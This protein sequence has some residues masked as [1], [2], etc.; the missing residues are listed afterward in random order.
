[1]NNE[2]YEQLKKIG[3]YPNRKVST[4][5]P[6]CLKC[7]VNFIEEYG[8]LRYSNN[9]TS[10]HYQFIK[11]FNILYLNEIELVPIGFVTN[12]IFGTLG[13][14]INKYE[15]IYV[16]DYKKYHKKIA[17]SI[18]MFFEEIFSDNFFIQATIDERTFE[19]LTKSGW[20][21]TRKI[22]ISNMYNYIISNNVPFFESAYNF[23]QNFYNLSGKTWGEDAMDWRIFDEYDIIDKKYISKPN[24]LHYVEENYIPIC[25][26]DNGLINY[27]ITTTGKIYNE[28]GTL[29][30]NNIMEGINSIL[31]N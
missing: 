13:I 4:I 22:D 30:G 21:P 12:S 10:M 26:L 31:R 15:E 23:F 7:A 11:Q 3:W 25:T 29:V 6:N 5:K 14:A 16:S 8:G 19:V 28:M 20:S 1:M 27:Y 18:E 2:I 24:I 9:N 17:N